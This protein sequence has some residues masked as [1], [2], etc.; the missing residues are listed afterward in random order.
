MGAAETNRLNAT[1]WE[2]ARDESINTCLAQWLSTVRARAHHEAL[3]NA[4]VEG[5][6][7][8]YV[9]DVLGP[10]GPMLQVLSKNEK[11]NDALEETWYQWWAMPDINEIL[12]GVDLLGL[13]IEDLW[14]SGEYLNQIVS[15]QTTSHPIKIRLNIITPRRLA[16]P[17]QFMGDDQLTL[18]IRRTRSGKPLA[19]YI[20]EAPI[21]ESSGALSLEYKEIPAA[22]IIHQFRVREAGQ[23]RG[24]PWLTSSLQ[25]VAD[26]R[27]YDVQVLDAARIAADQSLYLRTNHAD[28]KFELM[29]ETTDIE[30]RTISTLPPHYDL[31]SFT[32]QQP[33][34]VYVEFVAEKLR[35]LGR[36]VGMPLMMVQL[37][38]RK[39]NY[40]SARFDSQ[41][42]QRGINKTRAWIERYT[43]NRLAML[44]ATE[45]E[46]AG[47]IP[48]RPDFVRCT[49]IWPMFANVDPKKE[50]EAV[51][52]R[53]KNATGTYRDEC[54]AKNQHWEDIFEQQAKE[55]EK[56]RELGLPDLASLTSSK[57]VNKNEDENDEDEK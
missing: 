49:W 7:A 51:T 36:P 6:I 20:E 22:N 27:D 21:G 10:K 46:L 37:D 4:D 29:D 15:D 18:G 42:Y 1:H 2:N 55:A 40:S 53:L 13:D 52:E 32:P 8:T 19:Y 25:I 34:T 23:A 43:L 24:V 12:A 44:L 26:L 33:S 56:R 3:H 35:K 47:I 30:G 5:T 39:H 45:A 16:T 28:A 48:E 31:A 17:L 11:Y 9:N 57:V 50:E 54:A 14:K 38:S 41:V